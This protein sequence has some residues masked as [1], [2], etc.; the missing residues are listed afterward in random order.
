[1]AK[2]IC[3]SAVVV[4][5]LLLASTG[6]TKGEERK[7]CEWESK[8]LPNW[9]CWYNNLGKKVCDDLCKGEGA[10]YG[11]CLPNSGHCHCHLRN[12]P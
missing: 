3:F 9:N 11:V 1:M 12:C 8:N 7:R 6:T 2:S 5:F 10:D 4:I